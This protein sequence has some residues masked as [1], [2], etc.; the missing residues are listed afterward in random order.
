MSHSSA[1][2]INSY[3][4]SYGHS[5]ISLSRRISD[6]V[7]VE[8][9][10]Q[11]LPVPDIKAKFLDIV[12]SGKAKVGRFP[13]RPFCRSRRIRVCGRE[14]PVAYMTSLKYS[15]WKLSSMPLPQKAMAMLLVPEIVP[16]ATTAAPSIP[17]AFAEKATLC[18]ARS[19]PP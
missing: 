3:P 2:S 18:F 11:D 5:L 9:A 12:T 8:T 4:Y 6:S 7:T 1:V 19:C 14:G 13:C 15:A 10:C 17:F 16:P